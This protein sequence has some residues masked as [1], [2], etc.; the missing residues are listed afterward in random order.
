[1]EVKE[2]GHLV[3]YVRNVERSAAFYRDVLGWRQIVG[4]GTP[5]AE[6]TRPWASAAFSA[7]NGRTHH[8]L[9][10]IEVGEDAQGLPQ[11]RHVGLYHFGIKVGETDDE[12]RAALAH[13]QEHDVRFVGASDHTVTHSL[14]IL[15][16]DGNEIE[17]YVDVPDVDWR[18]DPTLF[19]APV[20]P[21]SL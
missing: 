2:L 14:Y 15:D 13:M 4:P 5:G 8:E 17:V 7:P 3:L 20:R 21:L 6:Q 16:P 11:G 18:T 19:A 1:M 12:L 9:L 10:L